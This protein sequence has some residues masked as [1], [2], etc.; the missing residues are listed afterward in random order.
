M[1]KIILFSLILS[2]HL[3][4]A[5]KLTIKGQLLDS[6]SSPLPSAT[7][8][9]LQSKDS[10]LVNFGTSDSKGFFEI[11]NVV[12]GEYFV[13]VS[14]LGFAPYMKRII[15]GEGMIEVNLGQ[16]RLLNKSTMLNEVVIR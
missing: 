2:A 14:F 16:I 15:P 13:K 6:A 12:R 3:G 4:F 7:V 8:I 5:Q 9:I 11:R 10:S 1:K